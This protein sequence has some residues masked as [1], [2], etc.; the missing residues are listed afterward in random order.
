MAEASWLTVGNSKTK[1]DETFCAAR[2]AAGSSATRREPI[3]LFLRN[4]ELKLKE[5]QRTGP[6]EE[7][8]ETHDEVSFRF[9]QSPSL[10]E[11][12]ER[13]MNG[14]LRAHHAAC[15]IPKRRAARVH[16][17]AIGIT[18]SVHAEAGG[19]VPGF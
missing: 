7:G 11:K 19:L 2:R 12:G 1:F 9:F 4:V 6:G 8:N 16:Q 17:P 18:Q 15:V 3:I 5:Q 14:T 13:K 10:N